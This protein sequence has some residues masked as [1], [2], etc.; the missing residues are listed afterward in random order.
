VLLALVAVSAFSA[1]AVASAS[2][3]E[4]VASKTGAL[5]AT[6]TTPVKFYFGTLEEPTCKKATASGSITALKFKV[7]TAK[8]AYSECGIGGGLSFKIEPFTVEYEIN[9]ENKVAYHTFLQEM[10]ILGCK[11][12]WIPI[13]AE[14]DAASYSNSAPV[15]TVTSVR[16]SKHMKVEAVFGSSSE[17]HGEGEAWKFDSGTKGYYTETGTWNETSSLGVEGGTLQWK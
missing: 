15:K 5:T 6:V 13:A 7:L 16:T 9:A 14:E 2:A 1:T 12:K 8:V 11:W 10:P 4:F 17:C 3:H